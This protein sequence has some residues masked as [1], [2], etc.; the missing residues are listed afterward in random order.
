MGERYYV[1]R[2]RLHKS[3]PLPHP[4]VFVSVIDGKLEHLTGDVV[5]SSL[6]E[7]Q[8]G[9]LK[10]K[11]EAKCEYEILSFRNK[12]QCDWYIT[13]YNEQL[14]D[15]ARRERIHSMRE[16]TGSFSPFG[17]DRAI[18]PLGGND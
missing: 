1:V 7:L 3:M 13:G 17:G 18:T 5:I 6:L 10:I 8:D 4:T 12:E 11:K 16:A 2:E 15:K 14:R 9:E